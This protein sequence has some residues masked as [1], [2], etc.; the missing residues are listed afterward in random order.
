LQIFTKDNTNQ[1]LVATAMLGFMQ[2][3]AH[4]IPILVKNINPAKLVSTPFGGQGL[5]DI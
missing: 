1:E 2:R 4:G 3:T 5:L